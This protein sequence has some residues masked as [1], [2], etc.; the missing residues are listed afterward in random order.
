[1]KLRWMMAVVVCAV[2]LTACN[3]AYY[4][5]WE[6]LGREKRDLL[7]SNVHSARDAQVDAAEEFKD[8]LTQLKELTGFSGGNL[9]VKYNTLN[10]EYKDCESKSNA[11]KSRIAKVQQIA[12]DLFKEWETEIGTMSNANLKSQSRQQL[13]QTRVR[14]KQLEATMKSA[15]KRLDPVLVQFR[16]QVLFLKHNLNAQAIAGLQGEVQSIEV[17]VAALIKEMN[18]SIAEADSFIKNMPKS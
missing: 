2:A 18:K 17:D 6:T 15:E 11:V 5:M 13:E 14:F 4:S 3:T 1:M 16:D 8:A 12:G 9:E 7:I 10:A